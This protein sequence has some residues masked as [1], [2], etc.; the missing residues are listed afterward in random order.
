MVIGAR[1]GT[2]G[3]AIL[4][5]VP[6]L[7]LEPTSVAEAAEALAA[8][9][10][11]RL[12]VAFVGGATELELGAPPTAL[13]VVLRTTRLKRVVEYA[14]ADQIAVL[15]AGLTLQEVAQHLAT[16][17]QRLAL[18]PPLAARA[19]IGGVVAANAWG[20]RR[21]RFGA[22]R[23]LVV[24]MSFV[25]ADGVL[26]KGGGKVVKNV[27]GFDVPRLLAGSLGTLAL[28][29]TVTVR[30]HPL[31]EAES[32]VL[33]ANLAPAEAR[34]LVQALLASQLEPTSVA[35]FLEGEHL[36][37]GVRFE[38][39]G[40][41]VAQQRERLLALADERKLSAEVLDDGAARAFW[42]RHDVLR[43]EGELRAKIAAPPASLP[44]MTRGA[45]RP[46]LANGASAAVV[47]PTLGVAFTSGHVGDDPGRAVAAI[48]AARAALTR[49]GG[50]L[51]VTAAPAAVREAV[52]V[53]GP[54][55]ASLALMRR[56]KAELDPDH[57]LAPGRFVGGL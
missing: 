17:H 55:P 1:E 12:R 34:G 35:G 44:D 40:P 11:D 50:T 2:P 36:R 47:Y 18:D 9:A 32:T 5:V 39:F 42:S 20:P 22:S 13:D 26:A 30:L 23:D 8:C 10:R 49:L 3:D 27:A 38:G 52:D 41:G 24:G 25:R 46:L 6:R 51:V 21:H 54:P 33:L 29:A 31:P 15:E 45:L 19:T 16:H 7:V 43:S 53:W 37:I 4:G 14:P 56:V 48:G 57:R 28:I